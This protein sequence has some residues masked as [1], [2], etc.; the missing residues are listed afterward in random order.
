[1]DR[2]LLDRLEEEVSRIPGVRRASVSGENAATEIHLL[3]SSDRS[4]KQIVRDVQSLAAAAF[5][6]RLDHRIV[7]VVQLDE[8]KA[9]SAD[10]EQAASP[11]EP[12]R[13]RPVLERVVLASTAGGAW[14]KVALKWSDGTTTEGSRMVTDT[15][16]SRARGASDAAAAAVCEALEDSGVRLEVEDVGIQ[17]VGPEDSVVVRAR[18]HK[19]GARTD[20]MGSAIVRDDVATAAARALLHAVNRKLI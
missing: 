9:P 1:M 16:E 10:E 18:H 11:G 7:S 2:E 12:V 5:G 17:R 20:L 6:L 14:V 13:R 15:R 3:A 19:N 4:P 8:A